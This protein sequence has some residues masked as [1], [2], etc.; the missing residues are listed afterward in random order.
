MRIMYLQGKN[1]ID[2]YVGFFLGVSQEME[3]ALTRWQAFARSIRTA[4]KGAA[5]EG[6]KGASPEGD[7]RGSHP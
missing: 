7:P 5:Q 4:Q 3:S 1:F 6:G 2:F